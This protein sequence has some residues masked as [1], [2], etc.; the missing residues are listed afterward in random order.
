[1]GLIARC[2]CCAKPIVT[3]EYADENHDAAVCA[4]CA[5]A[6]IGQ[7]R[8]IAQQ[9]LEGAVS[10]LAAILRLTYHEDMPDHLADAI[11][12]L[13]MHPANHPGGQ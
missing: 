5:V 6:L 8:D 4:D 9:Q 7:E 3:G 1:M 10:N 12:P 2:D 13:C 11:R